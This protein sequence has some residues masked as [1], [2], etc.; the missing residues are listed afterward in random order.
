[1]TAAT[2]DAGKALTKAE[3]ELLSFILENGP[4]TLPLTKQSKVPAHVSRLVGAGYL[5]TLN[6]LRPSSAM[7]E[8]TDAGRAALEKDASNG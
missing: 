4:G 2:P 8:I 1:M 7:Y 6:R 5:E 3:R